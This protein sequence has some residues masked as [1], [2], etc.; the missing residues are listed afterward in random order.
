MFARKTLAAGLVAMSALVAVPASA[1]T[2]G[3]DFTQ[4]GP[5]VV[6]DNGRGYDRDRR[7]DRGRW[8]RDRHQSRY[9]SA[10]EVRRVLRSRGYR[11]INYVDRNG[12]IYRARA[13]DYRGRMV[14]LTINARNGVILDSD[15]LR[16]G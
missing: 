6:F 10:N 16:R 1:A 3:V 8:D 5:V 4:R 13:V 15:R 14:A 11:N 7:D 12:S 9:L 2:I